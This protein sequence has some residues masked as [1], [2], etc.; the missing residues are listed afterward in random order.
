[1]NEDYLAHYGIKRRSGRYPWGSGVRPFQSI[2]LTKGTKRSKVYREEHV[3]PKGTKVYQTDR[4]GK[5]ER[6]LNPSNSV[7]YM[8][9]DRDDANSFRV[10][11]RMSNVRKV[12]REMELT[13]DIKVP[14]RQRLKDVIND[15]INKN[16][17]LLDESLA[18]LIKHNNTRIDGAT[19]A[20]SELDYL[21]N[22]A[23]DHV[24]S[25]SLDDRFSSLVESFETDNSLKKSVTEQ[26]K[27][28]GYDGMV[29]EYRVGAYKNR[30]TGADPIY[31]FDLDKTT[32][33]G[34][35]KELG[36]KEEEQA[37]ADYYKWARRARNN[38]VW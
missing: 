3:I 1:M 7:N 5:N 34:S 27:K 29:N 11:D 22:R 21:S 23:I 9:P 15:Q 8:K 17:K 13:K 2:K 10:S 30:A 38:K 24:R 32:K 18:A 35:S 26:L 14:S 31:L 20:Q 19:I 12:E 36:Q 16:P 4:I 37:S 28:E 33:K 25:Q 6:V